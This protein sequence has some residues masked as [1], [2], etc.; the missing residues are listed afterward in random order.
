M[1]CC[2]GRRGPKPDKTW[3]LAIDVVRAVDLISGNCWFGSRGSEGV[4]WATAIGCVEVDL[5]LHILYGA[6]GTKTYIF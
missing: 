1:F 2:S 6:L 3:S 5:T 4:G